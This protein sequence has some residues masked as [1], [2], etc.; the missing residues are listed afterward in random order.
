MDKFWEGA[1]EAAKITPK[2]T[3]TSAVYPAI[4]QSFVAGLRENPN[5]QLVSELYNRIPRET[6]ALQE[7]ALEVARQTVKTMEER[8]RVDLHPDGY[9]DVLNNFVA[10][11]L[12]KGEIEEGL[13]RAQGAVT[14]AEKCYDQDEKRFAPRLA[15]A[16]EH[17][18]SAYLFLQRHTEALEIM[19]KAL[20]L[21][22]ELAAATPT[23]YSRSLAISLNN[24]VSALTALGRLEE[25]AESAAEAV[26]RFRDIA[27]STNRP[28]ELKFGEGLEPWIADV[29]PD[30]AACLLAQSTVLSQL[31]RKQES[32]RAAQEA[33]EQL[34]TLDGDYPD[35]FRPLLAQAYNNIAMGLSATGR[36]EEA[37]AEIEKAVAQFTQLAAVRPTAYRHFLAHVLLSQS[38]ALMRLERW[39]D[40][41]EICQKAAGHYEQLSDERPEMFLQNLVGLSGFPNKTRGSS[42]VCRG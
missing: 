8:N 14:F 6:V 41:I 30:L 28:Q 40:A 3:G 22:Q 17:Q 29:R 16:L 4:D 31:D 19:D 12:Q 38:T 36:D 42:G 11:L 18:T 34:E 25:A 39:E 9:L 1:L 24:R 37:L 13:A 7:T 33:T 10:R 27:N 15:Q 35:Q 23:E 32:L 26:Q 21:Y 2:E 20:A 5:L